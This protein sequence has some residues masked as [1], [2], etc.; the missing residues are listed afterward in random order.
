MWSPYLGYIPHSIL[1]QE[2]YLSEPDLFPASRLYHKISN[3]PENPYP[4]ALASAQATY[5]S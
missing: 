2:G 1:S 4:C 3:K 5:I